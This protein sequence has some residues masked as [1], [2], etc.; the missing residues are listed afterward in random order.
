LERV[1]RAF[2]VYGAVTA[3]QQAVVTQVGDVF[4]D[5]GCRQMRDGEAGRF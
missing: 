4:V 3:L 2:L 5:Q 1:V